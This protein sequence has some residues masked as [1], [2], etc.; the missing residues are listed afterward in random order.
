MLI[1]EEHPMSACHAKAPNILEPASHGTAI[2]SCALDLMPPHLK[3]WS[4]GERFGS[5]RICDQGRRKVQRRQ[6]VFVAARSA[7]GN[8]ERFLFEICAC[9]T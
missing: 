1:C 5:I 3:A 4:E 2:A 8:S 7:T 6:Q 9:P